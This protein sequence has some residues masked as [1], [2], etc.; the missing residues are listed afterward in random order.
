M[1]QP[2]RTPPIVV[3]TSIPPI[4]AA[5]LQ[6]QWTVSIKIIQ[7]FPTLKGTPRRWDETWLASPKCAAGPCAVRLSGGIN[8]FIFKTTLTRAGSVYR[9]KITGNVFPCGSRSGSFP[10]RTTVRIRIAVTGAHV[11]NRAWTAR[12]WAGHMVLTAPYTASGSY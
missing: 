1:Q 4:S 12:S 6:G 3:S 11:D 10:I 8:G 2:E 9:G 7:G 5:R